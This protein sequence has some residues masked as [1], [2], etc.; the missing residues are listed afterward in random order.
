MR[1]FLYQTELWVRRHGTQNCAQ[2]HETLSFFYN[3]HEITTDNRKK[4][5][6]EALQNISPE[7]LLNGVRK[8]TFLFRIW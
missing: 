5:I 1:R 8:D 4:R 7:M 3:T 2:D 6:S